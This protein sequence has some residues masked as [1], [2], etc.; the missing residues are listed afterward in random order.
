MLSRIVYLF[1]RS[2]YKYTLFLRTYQ[3]HRVPFSRQVV[4]IS[5][6]LSCPTSLITSCSFF[7][8][9]PFLSYR[10]TVLYRPAIF[11]LLCF[12]IF[13]VCPLFSRRLISVLSWSLLS[14]LVHSWSIS[15]CLVM[16]ASSGPILFICFSLLG[17]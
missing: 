17:L 12:Y 2:F 6:V 5:S 13:L 1:P 10:P 3:S 11:F 4:L 7:S 9:C 15:S 14:C 8:S 16:S